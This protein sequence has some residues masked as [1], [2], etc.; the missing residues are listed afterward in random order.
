VGKTGEETY[1]LLQVAITDRPLS[2]ST[3]GWLF[4]LKNV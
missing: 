3:W 1:G 4:Y 2:W